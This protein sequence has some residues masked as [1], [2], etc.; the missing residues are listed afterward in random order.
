MVARVALL[1]L[2]AVFLC[3]GTAFLGVGLHQALL[4]AMAPW[5]ASLVTGLIALIIAGLFAVVGAH[6]N[7]GS[8]S[9]LGGSGLNA[10]AAS[11][12]RAVETNPLV[13]VA[14]AA[15]VGI[16]QSFLAGRRR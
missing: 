11:I 2:A 5:A 14:A 4:L 8:S 12:S 7:S 16:V 10:A 13:A 1:F 15:A 3:V 9:A 6:W